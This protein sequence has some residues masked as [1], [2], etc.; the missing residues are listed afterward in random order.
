MKAGKHLVEWDHLTYVMLP[1][2]I[3]L[4]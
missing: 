3:K 4:V 1:W 2:E